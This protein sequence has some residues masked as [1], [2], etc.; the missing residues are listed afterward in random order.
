MSNCRGLLYYWG[1]I[2]LVQGFDF[3]CKGLIYQAHLFECINKLSGFNFS[4]I[5]VWFFLCRGLIYQVHL[6][7]INIICSIGI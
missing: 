7:V 3:F 2:H 6:F 4:Y 1:L 5:C